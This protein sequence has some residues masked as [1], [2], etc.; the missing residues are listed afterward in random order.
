MGIALQGKIPGALVND[1]ATVSRVVPITIRL[2]GN[3]SI[4][5]TAEP[6]VVVDGVIID[7][8]TDALLDISSNTRAAAPR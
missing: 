8:T 1:C 6:L 2:R 7:N 4:L 5:G 3:N